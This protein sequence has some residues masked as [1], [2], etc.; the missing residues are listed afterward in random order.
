MQAETE[1]AIIER[2]ATLAAAKQAEYERL[3]PQEQQEAGQKLL[4]ACCQIL[5]TAQLSRSV[6]DAAC[7]NFAD[8]TGKPAACQKSREQKQEGWLFACL[9]PQRGPR[10]EPLTL[11]QLHESHASM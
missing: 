10:Y 1:A 6:Q 3:Q 2:D 9:W 5:S 4:Q 11:Q 7:D 8:M